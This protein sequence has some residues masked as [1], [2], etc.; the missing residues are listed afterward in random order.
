[1]VRYLYKRSLPDGTAELWCLMEY[2]SVDNKH[3]QFSFTLVHVWPKLK[4][5]TVFNL[6]IWYAIYACFI[7]AT[8]VCRSSFCM[9]Y[10]MCG[11]NSSCRKVI[12]SNESLLSQVE[13]VWFHHMQTLKYFWRNEFPDTLCRIKVTIRKEAVKQTTPSRCV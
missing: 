9:E 10:V 11:N 2:C 5:V 7:F 8:H 3:G 1:M 4:F 13:T 6:V 12:Q